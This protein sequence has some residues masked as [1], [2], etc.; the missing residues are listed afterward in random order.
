M[1][2]VYPVDV[3]FHLQYQVLYL[4]LLIGLGLI[5]GLDPLINFP[6]WSK[7]PVIVQGPLICIPD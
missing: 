6:D 1:Y 7:S 4:V 5:I 2:V 3:D